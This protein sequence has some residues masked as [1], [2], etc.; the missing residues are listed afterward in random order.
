M[1]KAMREPTKDDVFCKCHKLPVKYQK[2]E[3]GLL[4]VCS[5]TGKTCDAYIP[6]ER[7]KP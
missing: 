4:T 5:V 6:A 1:T 7:L 2:F 3:D